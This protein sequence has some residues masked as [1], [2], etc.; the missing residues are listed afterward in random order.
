MKQKYIKLNAQEQ[1]I[2]NLLREK[3]S[4]GAYVYEFTTSRPKGLGVS[5][6]NARIW[7]LRRKGHDIK[8]TTPG[9]FV[10]AG[11]IA[12]PK[13]PEYIFTQDGRAVAV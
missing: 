9:H 11:D 12:T 8:N 2:L 5:Q 4:Q 3:G 1:R 13:K 6:Y 10:L 7:G